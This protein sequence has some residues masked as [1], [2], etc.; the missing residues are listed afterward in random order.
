MLIPKKVKHRKWHKGRRSGK[1]LATQKTFLAFGAFGLKAMSEGWVTSRQ[2][3]AARRAM[4]RHMKRG[5]KIWIRI[6]PDHPIT[7]KGSEMPMGKGK[8][9][10][11]HYIAAVRTGTVLFEL[12]GIDEKI[13]EETLLLASYK[14]PLKTKI[15]RQ[16]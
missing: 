9:A 1:R 16:T 12:D 15:I 2:I 5:G 10:V 8:G 4:T 13:A 14:L 6:F 7:T 11:D 3:E